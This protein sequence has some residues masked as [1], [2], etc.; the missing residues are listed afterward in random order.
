MFAANTHKRPRKLC[1]ALGSNSS[2]SPRRGSHQTA[3]LFFLLGTPRSGQYTTPN[4]T[5]RTYFCFFRQ[6]DN[7]NKVPSFVHWAEHNLSK[8]ALTESGELKTAQRE[9]ETAVALVRARVHDLSRE[10]A[11][12]PKSKTIFHFVAPL[13]AKREAPHYFR[14]RKE[15]THKSTKRRVN[16]IGKHF[17]LAPPGA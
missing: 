12:V 17:S 10:Q 14:A 8:K 6:R 1:V 13:L 15:S 16:N 2:P 9:V 11:E 4:L 7:E 5:V 3:T